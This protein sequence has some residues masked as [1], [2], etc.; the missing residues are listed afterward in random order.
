MQRAWDGRTRWAA[1]A[2]AAMLM[3]AVGAGCGGRQSASS[4]DAIRNARTLTTPDRQ[5]DYL[6]A[7]A[8]GF[9]RK[10]DYQEAL[11]TLQYVLASVDMRSETAQQLLE[12][13]KTRLAREAQSVVVDGQRARGL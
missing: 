6:V 9:L 8:R 2:L 3:M 5:A 13:T 11:K 7:Q 12:E 1:A 4:S 10:K